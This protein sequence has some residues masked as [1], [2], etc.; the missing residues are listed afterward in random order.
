MPP[1]RRAKRGKRRK[2]AHTHS[3]AGESSTD[4][5]PPLGSRSRSGEKDGGLEFQ[6]CDGRQ[7]VCRIWTLLTLKEKRH[8][9]TLE[10]GDLERQLERRGLELRNKMLINSGKIAEIRRFSNL[11]CTISFL[12][13]SRAKGD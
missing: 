11:N 1:R 3:S 4:G 2:G 5:A 12:L 6:L 7:E 13:M 10:V 9:L 8:V